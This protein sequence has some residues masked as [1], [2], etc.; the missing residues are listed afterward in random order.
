MA[1]TFTAKF[2]IP[3]KKRIGEGKAKEK[4]GEKEKS[5]KLKGKRVELEENV[6]KNQGSDQKQ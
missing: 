2:T 1:K 5:I 3:T 6:M 4:G